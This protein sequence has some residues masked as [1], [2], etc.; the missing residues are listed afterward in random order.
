M[1]TCLRHCL[2]VLVDQAIEEEDGSGATFARDPW[3][4]EADG[5]FGLTTCLEVV[6]LDMRFQESRLSTGLLS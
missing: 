5:S 3:Q 6:C 2:W 1:L 4:R